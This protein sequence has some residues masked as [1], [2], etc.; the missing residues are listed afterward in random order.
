MKKTSAFWETVKQPTI[1]VCVITLVGG[2]FGGLFKL[3]DSNA[4]AQA[5]LKAQQKYQEKYDKIATD[6]IMLSVKCDTNH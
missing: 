6:Y 4:Q 2:G 5:E 3:L 1:I